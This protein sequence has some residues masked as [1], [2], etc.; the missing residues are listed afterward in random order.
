MTSATSLRRLALAAFL[1][2]ALGLATGCS[3]SSSG[4]DGTKT[5]KYPFGSR[6]QMYTAGTIRPSGTQAALDDAVKAKYQQWKDR[7]LVKGCGGYYVCANE[8]PGT[9]KNDGAAILAS[10]DGGLGIDGQPVDLHLTVSEGHGYGMLIAVLMA[11]VEPDARA[12]FDGFVTLRDNFRSPYDNNLMSW[13]FDAGCAITDVSDN[14]AATDGDLDSAFALLLAEKQWSSPHYGQRG[15][16]IIESIMNRELNPATKLPL[17]GDW[18]KPS[19]DPVDEALYFSTR[20]SDH[21]PDHFRQFATVSGNADWTAAVDASYK[22]FDV[23]QTKF[24][25][26]TGL[27]SDFVKHTDGDPQ[28]VAVGDADTMLGEDL[29]TDY[30]YNAC[31]VPW[32]L[33]TDYV[34]NGEARAKSI[35]TKMNTFIKTKT[36]ND[37]AMILDGYSLAGEP[38]SDAGPNG[39][40][41]ASFGVS[42]MIDPSN[43]AWLDAI[44]KNLVDGP[45]DDYYGDTIRLITMIVMSGNW[46][47]P[48]A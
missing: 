39:C 4:S 3:S 14:D 42:A 20:T 5:P 34:V 22:L 31:R 18:S 46:W 12:I 36:N 24:A 1:G 8:I 27:V 2:N 43:Q 29:T 15:R 35:L 21:M 33:G 44:W 28:P 38:H 32:R 41:T 45:V 6:P 10:T 37:P 26:K 40:F 23:M 47:G 17:L 48:P 13:H 25:P 30:D 7:Y 16:D 9:C 19:T 11:D